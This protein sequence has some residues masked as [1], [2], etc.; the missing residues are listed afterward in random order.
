MSTI[1]ELQQRETH[2]TEAIA[3]IQAEL[4]ELGG[5]EYRDC[6]LD[7]TPDRTAKKS[8]TR[9]RWFDADKRKR[10]RTLKGDE[11]GRAR[12]AIALWSEL[13]LM[14]AELAHVGEELLKFEAMAV[15]LGLEVP[16]TSTPRRQRR[17]DRKP[18]RSAD[19]QSIPNGAKVTVPR[20]W[21]AVVTGYLGE[22]RYSI[23]YNTGLPG[24]EDSYP[25]HCL[26]IE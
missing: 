24:E 10:C 15:R 11:V 8:Y 1:Q 13:A 14:T 23:R 3:T 17:G 9:L 12:K 25:A 5:D 16:T 20:G 7:E 26:T 21:E 2:L 19:V 4:E 6:W 22:N 18:A